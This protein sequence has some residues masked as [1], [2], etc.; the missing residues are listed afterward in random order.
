MNDSAGKLNLHSKEGCHLDV[1]ADPVECRNS[2]LSSIYVS[3]I[4][5][6]SV[7]D[8][9]LPEAGNIWGGVV[10]KSGEWLDK[11]RAAM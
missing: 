2:G 11:A 10:E 9:Q 7:C 8:P 5:V 3:P 4:Y 6:H 1:P